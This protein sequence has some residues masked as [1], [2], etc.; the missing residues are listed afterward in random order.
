MKVKI[1]WNKKK[2]SQVK[3]SFNSAMLR[4]LE[5]P[6]KYLGFFD[7]RKTYPYGSKLYL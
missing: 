7:S 5:D 2:K 3:F 6:Q 1:H 4:L